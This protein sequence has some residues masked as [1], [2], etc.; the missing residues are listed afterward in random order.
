MFS[1][2][3]SYTIVAFSQF[4]ALNVLSVLDSF[5]HWALQSNQNNR[6]VLAEIVLTHFYDLSLIATVS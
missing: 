6:N 3:F 5:F 4:G 1:D 2:V